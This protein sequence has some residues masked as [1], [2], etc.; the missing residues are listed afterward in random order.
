MRASFEHSWR[1]EQRGN[2]PFS[3]PLVNLMC[4]TGPAEASD[5]LE[6]LTLDTGDAPRYCKLGGAICYRKVDFDAWLDSRLSSSESD[7]GAK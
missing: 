3:R 6:T 4:A 2:V 1:I 7:G 5:K